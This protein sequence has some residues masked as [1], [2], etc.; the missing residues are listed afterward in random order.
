VAV[1]NRQPE[2]PPDTRRHTRI[3][4]VALGAGVVPFSGWLFVW[5]WQLASPILV[6]FGVVCLPMGLVLMY[7][8]VLACQPSD[9]PRVAQILQE[10]RRA[11]H[12]W[13]SDTPHQLSRYEPSLIPRNGPRHGRE[14]PVHD[15][16]RAS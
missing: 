9:A 12:G 1:R 11:R 10:R 16:A 2:R 5:S 7:G 8:A 6:V 13:V 4:L 14:R 15:P 3:V